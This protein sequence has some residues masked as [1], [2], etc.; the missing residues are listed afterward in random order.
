MNWDNP[1]DS[2]VRY[3]SHAHDCDIQKVCLSRDEGLICTSDR[4]G[5]TKL[6]D[7]E[8]LILIGECFDGDGSS[9]PEASSLHFIKPYPCLVHTDDDSGVRL[10]PTKPYQKT[11]RRS[12]L[13]FENGKAARIDGELRRGASATCSQSFVDLEGG[14]EIAP[15]VTTG[16]VLI[17]TDSRGAIQ[18]FN[19]GGPNDWVSMPFPRDKSSGNG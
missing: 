11:E 7:F 17:F 12:A 9:L 8:T 14:K 15:G 4:N 16:R 13:R 19:L 1:Q 3:T 6:W 18:S 10:I 5:R 2:L